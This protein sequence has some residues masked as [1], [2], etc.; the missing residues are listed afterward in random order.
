VAPA[1]VTLLV[2]DLQSLARAL[3]QNNRYPSLERILFHGRRRRV[4]AETPNHLRFQ[5][6]ESEPADHMPVAAL[7]YVSSRGEA[8]DGRS[9]WLRADPVTMRADM[10]RVFMLSSGFADLDPGEQ[11]EVSLIIRAALEQDGIEL[12]E[13]EAAHWC[14]SL[15]SPL[16]FEFTPL[17]KALGMDVAEALP[18]EKAAARWKRLMT[19]IQVE[20]HQSQV[21]MKRRSQGRQEINSIWF[22]GGGYLPEVP[23]Q[24][25]DKVLS[26]DPVSRGLGILAGSQ[27]SDQE[28]FSVN[29]GATL[30]DWTMESANAENEADRLEKLATQLIGSA[31]VRAGGVTLLD[32]N[33]LAWDFS[34]HRQFA[35]WRRQKSLASAFPEDELP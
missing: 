35:F 13:V 3:P 22:W 25:F 34:R 6:F 32:G 21:N 24:R 7:T 17:H 8:P 29:N 31:S 16:E 1:S 9:Y 10:V 14:F 26:N 28:Q 33:G 2:E 18:E 27:V 23:G 20:L 30:I 19:E 12:A 11:K 4:P 15:N 5:L